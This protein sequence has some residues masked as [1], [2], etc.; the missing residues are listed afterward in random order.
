MKLESEICRKVYDHHTILKGEIATVLL[1]S[2]TRAGLSKD[3]IT[4]IVG[5]VD[6][7]V[8]VSTDR[9]VNDYQRTLHT[10]K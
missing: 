1:E 4:T 7:T 5:L 9:L 10:A 8:D 6:V 2:C 3:S